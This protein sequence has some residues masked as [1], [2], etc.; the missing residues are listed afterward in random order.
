[1]P[2]HAMKLCCPL[3]AILSFLNLCTPPITI[4]QGCFCGWNANLVVPSGNIVI[5]D[6]VNEMIT[7]FVNGRLVQQHHP[8]R[9]FFGFGPSGATLLPTSSQ[10]FVVTTLITSSATIDVYQDSTKHDS[11]S[12]A[13]YYGMCNSPCRGHQHS[14]RRWKQFDSQVAISIH[15]YY[16]E[17][18]IPNRDAISKAI[19]LD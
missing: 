3:M 6:C 1:M 16:L 15:E 17:G 9:S 7:Y 8:R 19:R 5:S 4:I 10:A 13:A 11:R 18:Y 14:N 2:L 12:Y